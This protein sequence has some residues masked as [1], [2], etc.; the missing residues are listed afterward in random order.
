MNLKTL[1]YYLLIGC[2]TISISSN[3]SCKKEDTQTE[4][5]AAKTLPVLSTSNI[6]VITQNS[7][8]SG[9]II[10]LQGDTS[11]LEKGICWSSNPS[12]TTNDHKTAAGNGAAGF[13]ST[14]TGLTKSTKYY[15]RAYATNS[16]GTSYGNELSFITT[17]NIAIGQNHAGG[18][19]FYVDDAGEHGLVSAPNDQSDSASWGCEGTSVPGTSTVVGSGPAN[20]LKIIGICSASNIAARICYDLVLNGYSDWYL[21]SRDELF[22][23]HQNLYKNRVGNFKI[24]R[25]WSSSQYD[26]TTAHY[27]FFNENI[28]QG[29]YFKNLIPYYV[30]AIRRF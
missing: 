15:V 24:M 7:A 29:Y 20:T 2:F 30:R 5:E 1:S 8:I 3:L 17:E 25:Y 27:Q 19:V 13:S 14:L 10:S 23:M 9:G 18:F 22:L 6:K 28:N 16:N 4:K 11:I 12:P 21:P 26:G